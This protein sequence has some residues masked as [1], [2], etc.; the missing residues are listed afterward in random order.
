VSSRRHGEQVRVRLLALLAA[1]ALLT[2][3][4]GDDGSAS[5][6]PSDV[7]T[8][9]PVLG[10]SHV[11]LPAPGA[12]GVL[13]VTGPPEG[14]PGTGPM[15]LWRWDGDAWSEVK[16]PGP[17]PTARSFFA[18]AHDPVRDVVVVYG[19]EDAQGFSDETWE[20]DGTVWRR[21]AGGA[22][23]ARSAASLAWDPTSSRV[24]LFG[25]NGADADPGAIRGD[26]WAWDGQD[27]TR[28]SE[29]GPV[30]A[31]WPAAMVAADAGQLL[32]FGGHQVADEDLPPALGDTWVLTDR[33]WALRADAGGPG[34]LV[35]AQAL[36]HPT[37]GIL[38][39][40]GSDF[41]RENGD[42]WRWT[43]DRWET[44]ARDVLPPRQAFGMAY[45]E[46]RG[47]VVLTGG[48]V[49]PGDTA[50]H[51]DVWEWSGSP[52]EPAVLVDDRPPA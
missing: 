46:A 21:S 1:C 16:A 11:L 10:A 2:G 34:P 30:P 35:N 23:G 5:S 45:D 3:C 15:P 33:A 20:W 22:P 26:T 51:Q 36:V 40:G 24:T 50:R 7:G 37:L 47:V 17:A 27:W 43:G 14:D 49:Q 38:L 13:L 6:T 25:G 28:V 19:G 8:S 52:E 41:D 32:V 4:S 44:F 31:R 29:T 12:D 18:A 42:V 48:V 9:G 39:A